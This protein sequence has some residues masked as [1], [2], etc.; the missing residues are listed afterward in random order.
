MEFNVKCLNKLYEELPWLEGIHR[1]RFIFIY[2]NCAKILYGAKA[3]YEKVIEL[4]ENMFEPLSMLEVQY[5]VYHTDTHIEESKWHSDGYYLFSP[6]G[7]IEYMELTD[8]TAEVCGFFDVQKK[9]QK[10][11]EHNNLSAERD[12]I[13]AKL[14]IKDKLSLKKIEKV[15]PE[16]YK[17][18]IGTIRNT[19]KRLNINKSHKGCEE[20]LEQLNF[21]SCR[22]YQ[23][24]AST[25]DTEE[26]IGAKDSSNKIDEN[27]C[28]TFMETIL[29]TDFK[30]VSKEE[31]KLDT[32]RKVVTFDNFVTQEAKELYELH[33]QNKTEND[34]AVRAN[35]LTAIRRGEN[36]LLLGSGGT[37][38]T[39]LMLEAFTEEELEETWFIAANGKASTHLP[40]GRTIH[41]AFQMPI[42]IQ[43]PLMHN[44]Y[45]ISLH[46]IKRIIIDEIGQVR[47]DIFQHMMEVLHYISCQYHRE[48]QIILLGDFGQICPVVTKEEVLDLYRYYKGKYAFHSFEWNRL[49][50]KK[51]I[52]QHSKRHIEKDFAEQLE[53]LRFGCLDA[54]HY[55]NNVLDK[56]ASKTAITICPTNRLVTRYNQQNIKQFTNRKTYKGIVDGSINYAQLETKYKDLELAVDMRIMAVKNTKEFKNGMLG[57]ITKI[58]EKSIW[59]KFDELEAPIKVTPYT[60]HQEHGSFTQYPITYGYAIT[61]D[62]S[63]GMTLDEVN[64]IPGYFAIGQV[65]TALSRC[66]SMK[67]IHL[68]GTF[69]DKELLVDVEALRYCI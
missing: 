34:E 43:L 9:K 15:L 25:S 50:L 47:S 36:I 54:L 12:K 66:R 69:K 65:Y 63:Q 3:A 67:G 58:N 2:Y 22:R 29:N 49:G 8:A 64:I 31:E 14:F 42:G 53:A 24:K 48:V 16:E 23:R 21:D 39:H 18:S 51:F 41:N 61:A 19:L 13:I 33:L 27:S 68:L 5:A 55:F 35:A 62:K 10:Y 38:K 46:K 52:L 28:Q 6:R 56:T 4:N 20:Y 1:E 59:V 17:C 45:P 60:F 40:N 26:I 44:N 7:I 57:T 11:M 32:E 37:G 30:N